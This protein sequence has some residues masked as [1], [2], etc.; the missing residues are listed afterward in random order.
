MTDEDS[1]IV[2]RFDEL[3]AAGKAI[4][5]S[6]ADSDYVDSAEYVG[7]TTRCVT[8][9]A[10]AVAEGS[11][12]RDALD[13]FKRRHSSSADRDSLVAQLA[14]I[15]ADYA[16][17]HLVV[18]PPHREQ[19]AIESVRLICRRF[20]AVARTLRS[21]HGDRPPFEVDDEHDVQTLLHALLRL[22]FE[23]VRPEDP[24]PKRAGA[25]SRIDFVLPGTGIVIEVKMTRRR[26]GQK[27]VGEELAVDFERYR[28][29]PEC[30]FLFCFVY[31]P[32]G[33][34]SN[35]AELERDLSGDKGGLTTEVVVFPKD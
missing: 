7:W 21:R 17:G 10:N 3:I 30:Q 35:P 22:F 23:D 27:E 1:E 11:P 6:G 8:L 14:A 15:R 32:E 18:A 31:D 29:H 28:S 25:S 24:A 16:A 19:H 13:R 5:R 33:R 12:H 26:L 9:L 20:R 4:T 34:I 2:R